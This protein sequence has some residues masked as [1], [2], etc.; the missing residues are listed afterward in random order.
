[1]L[2]IT[3]LA[4]NVSREKED[5]LFYLHQHCGS[6]SYRSKSDDELEFSKRRWHVRCLPSTHARCIDKRRALNGQTITKVTDVWRTTTPQNAY[7]KFFGQFRPF[8]NIL[9]RVRISRQPTADFYPHMGPTRYQKK[10]ETAK[11]FFPFRQ[12]N[13]LARK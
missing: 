2:W 5:M 6:S 12:V 4:Y 3:L 9:I 10:K 1:M 8:R 7:P 13:L 11:K